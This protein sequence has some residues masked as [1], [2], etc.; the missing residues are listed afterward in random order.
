MD[1][2]VCPECNK[3]FYLPLNVETVVCH[4]CGYTMLEREPAKDG[5]G[6]TAYILS[7]TKGTG[8]HA[9][10]SRSRKKPHC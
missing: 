8:N 6:D 3:A 5:M 7:M 1:L 10:A 4:F 2:R 9:E